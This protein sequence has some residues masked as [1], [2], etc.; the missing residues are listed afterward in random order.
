MNIASLSVR[1]I[2]L[3]LATLLM[4]R[5]LCNSEYTNWSRDV[6]QNATDPSVPFYLAVT[7]V[8][9]D[10][11]F[12]L[13]MY[14]LVKGRKPVVVHGKRDSE[15]NFCPAIVYEVAIRGKGEWKQVVKSGQA[16]NLESVTISSDNPTVR[17][18]VDMQ[19]FQSL[20]D[21]FRWGRLVL[22]NGDAALFELE[23]LLP[24]ANRREASADFKETV[25]ERESTRF[26]S[27]AI[28]YS[29]TSISNRRTGVFVYSPPSLATLKGNETPDGDFWPSV[30][31]YVGNSEQDWRAIDVSKDDMKTS[32]RILD[33]N[34]PGQ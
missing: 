10:Q 11:L 28:L 27:S 23:D 2:G 25:D 3:A 20:I 7:S 22:E 31:L 16:A 21:D 29:V 5:G 14:Q 13:C 24:P 6:V 15:G 17:F 12:A 30:T 4:P 19:Q 1:L 9:D 8:I 33:K 18:K 34:K 26:G 32:E